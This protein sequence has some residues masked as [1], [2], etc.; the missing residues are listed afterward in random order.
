MM[1]ATNK[2]LAMSIIKNAHKAKMGDMESMDYVDK[3]DNKPKVEVEIEMG[4]EEEEDLKPSYGLE[5]AMSKFMLAMAAKDP[6]K[7]AE[8]MKEFM[9]MCDDE[10]YS[11][12]PSKEV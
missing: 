6:K 2:K 8:A 7:A 10:F 12:E 4:G 5:A 1:M 9:A 3:G 11:T